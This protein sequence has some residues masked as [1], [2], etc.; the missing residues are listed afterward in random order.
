M[1]ATKAVP[2]VTDNVG[3]TPVDDMRST[4][5]IS[6]SEILPSSSSADMSAGKPGAP[7]IAM[8]QH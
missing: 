8:S 5:R 3:I 7:P 4:P 2:A 6:S 1:I